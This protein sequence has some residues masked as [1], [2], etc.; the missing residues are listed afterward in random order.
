M[1]TVLVVGGAGY[2]GSHCAKVLAASGY[3][4]V[5]YDNFSTGNRDFV[6][7]GPMVEGDVRDIGELRQAIEN[8]TPAAIMHFAALISVGESVEDPQSYYDVNVG[9][10]LSLLNAMVDMNVR[11]LVFS[12]T[13]AVYGDPRRV[14]ITECE[15]LMPLNTYGN[16]KVA[17]EKMMED[18]EKAHG[19][20]S[21]RLRYFNAAGA[22]PEAEIGENHEPETHLIPLA[23]DVVID[24]KPDITIFGDDYPTPDGTAIRD[25]VHVMDLAKAHV[26]AL[27]YLLQGNEGVAVNLGT[28]EGA[29][30]LEVIETVEKV[31]GRSVSRSVLPRRQGDSA[32]LVA[33]PRM[34][35]TVLG[36]K[37]AENSLENI[38][39]DAW[40][41]HCK[42]FGT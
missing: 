37:G 23:L 30:V 40:R 6:R 34:G 14:P 12:S 17:C 10:T 2:V 9:G 1:K 27:E 8:Y 28:G 19:I 11:N 29:S 5:V 35:R 41:W 33:D 20:R 18:Y 25:Y 36:W 26:Y 42:R 15:K 24:K 3:Q 39:S 22:D 32:S 4:P 16:T 21:V 31:V 13:A 38:I 7:W